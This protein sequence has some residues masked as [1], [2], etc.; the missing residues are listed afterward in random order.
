M[1]LFYN[2]DI[3]SIDSQF[4][5]DKTESRHIVKVLRKKEDDLL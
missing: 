5:F 1:Q 2:K 3:S 4:T